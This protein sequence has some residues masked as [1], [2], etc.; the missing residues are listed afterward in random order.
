MSEHRSQDTVVALIPARS[1]SQR[2]PGKNV[3]RLG[4]HP[5]LAYTIAAARQSGVF[6]AVVVST[7]DADYAR[8]A[9]YYGAEAPFLRPAEFAGASSPD[10]EWVSHALQSLAAS[11]REFDCFSILRPTSPFR[12]AAVIQRAWKMFAGD[13]AADSLRAVEKCAQH[14]GK[15][16]VER[17]GRLLPLLPF[18][19]AQQPWHSTPYQALPAIYVQ[20]ASLEVAR[21]RVVRESGTISGEVVMPFFT[22]GAEGLDINVPED[23]WYAEHLLA[24]GEA[25]LPPVTQAPFAGALCAQGNAVE[26][27]ARAEGGA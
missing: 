7:D 10:I 4:A 3:R 6:A 19:T 9:E 20:N 22:H 16:W 17:G 26:F 15:M 24:R 12:D 8:L 18:A 14:P 1:G 5:L 13:A 21:S 2:V 11:G 27:R 25:R 23:W